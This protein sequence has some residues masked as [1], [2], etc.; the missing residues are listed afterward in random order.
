MV[1]KRAK[2]WHGV[3]AVDVGGLTYKVIRKKLKRSAGSIIMGQCDFNT[4]EI[5]L[6]TELNNQETGFVIFHELI[7]ASHDAS[8]CDKVDYESEDFLHPFS[9]HLWA[10]MCDAGLINK[11]WIKR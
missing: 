5:R 1:L 9:R 2:K 10:A 11:K 7:H 8:S 3:K 6:H 4:R